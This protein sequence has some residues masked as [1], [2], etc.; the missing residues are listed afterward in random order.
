MIIIDDFF[1]Q[2][3][4]DGELSSSF[5]LSYYPHRLADFDAMLTEVFGKDAFHETFG[6]FKALNDIKDPA[7]YIH[8][9]Q[10]KQN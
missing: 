6:D 8:F 10:K 7:F 3:R 4:Y 5:R 2:G 9:I 1:K